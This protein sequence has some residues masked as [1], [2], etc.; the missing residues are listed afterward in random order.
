MTKD[1]FAKIKP[2]HQIAGKIGSLVSQCMKEPVQD[3]A[4][5][6]EGTIAKLKH[7]SL[8]KPFCQAF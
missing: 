4:I 2:Y 8:Q 5:Q 3:V 7:R 6:Y 1:E